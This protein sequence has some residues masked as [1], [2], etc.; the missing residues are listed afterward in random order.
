[1]SITCFAHLNAP[2]AELYTGILSVFARARAEFQLNLRASEV[3][4]PLNETVG[5]ECDEESIAAAMDQLCQ[6]GNLEAFHDNSLALSLEDFYK[7]H[8]YYQ[9]TGSGVAAMRAIELFRQLIDTPASL[10]ATALAAVRDRLAELIAMAKAQE[11][12]DA[13]PFDA[14]KAS[15]LLD[16]LF[17]EL[18]SLTDQAQEFFRNLQATVEL[19]GTSV[20]AF[21]AFKERLVHYLERFLNQVVL[22]AAEAEGMIESADTMMVDAM[23][24]S[25]ATHRTI[26]EMDV[27]SDRIADVADVLGS[28][29]RGV[30]GW[31]VAI[32][33][34]TSQAD[35]LRGL[36]RTGI[37]EVAAA[38]SRLNQRRSGATDRSADLR[39]LAIAFARC[40][41]PRDAHRL[42][43]TAFAISPARHFTVSD[44]TLIDRDQRP[45]PPTTSWSDSPPLMIAPSLRKTGRVARSARL[46]RIVDNRSQLARLR[47]EAEREAEQIQQ[48]H[49]A[50][51]THGTRR[52]SELSAMDAS[53]FP[54]FLDLL[55]EA[56]TLR[57]HED[58][59]V[60]ATSTDGA[61]AIEL[62]STGDGQ[63]CHLESAWGIFHGPDFFLRIFPFD[64][65]TASS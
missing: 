48:A 47:I 14:A 64:D 29:W 17:Q 12:P 52:I 31:F 11:R 62:R 46:P 18:D 10:Q 34:R 55:G 65:S 8:L 51:L 38:A 30:A 42:W 41:S 13:A 2:N 35:E 3:R 4:G 40:G 54:L 63:T 59:F 27:T 50:L 37:R 44:A 45:I 9:L 56:L 22:V 32:D 23:L 58:E 21:L 28:R 53:A 15:S 5:Q 39:T 6:W 24:H 36:A 43:R 19:R 1:M 16:V 25:I 61:L 20:D 7:R 26:D 57:G 60:E 33:G 49:A